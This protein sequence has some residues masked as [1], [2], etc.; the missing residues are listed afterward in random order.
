MYIFSVKIAGATCVA[1]AFVSKE[2]S[3]VDTLPMT[4]GVP[5]KCAFDLVFALRD[6]DRTMRD[7]NNVG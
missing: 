6:G 1:S 3:L 5:P 2:S 7:F 4:L